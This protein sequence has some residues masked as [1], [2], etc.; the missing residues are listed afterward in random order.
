MK[1]LFDLFP[2]ILFF[3]AFKVFDIYVATG[4]VIAATVAIAVER[5]RERPPSIAPPE[6]DSHDSAPAD[7]RPP[8]RRRHTVDLTRDDGLRDDG[9]SDTEAI[10]VI[11][12]AYVASRRAS[13]E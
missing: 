6:F 11:D 4:V 2:I 5:P 8:A 13:N 9:R 1:F 12:E 3:I 7:S 10:P